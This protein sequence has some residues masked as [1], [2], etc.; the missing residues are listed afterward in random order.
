MPWPNGLNPEKLADFLCANMAPYQDTLED[1]L[2]GIN[3]AISRSGFIVLAFDK[4]QLMGCS[5]MVPTGMKGY[6]PENLLLFVAVARDYRNKGIGSRLI[7]HTISECRGK[8]K[9]HV[10]YDNPA[11]AL[12]ERMGFKF[13][14][15]DMRFTCE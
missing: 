5:V 15:A 11:L 4:D 1:T 9:L 2:R 6:V 13:K 10:E 7:K 3:D 8:I 14:Y 12:Y